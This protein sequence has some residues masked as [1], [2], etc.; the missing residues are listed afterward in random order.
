MRDEF[1]S[2]RSTGIPPL[3]ALAE[4]VA[5]RRSALTSFIKAGKDWPAVI[6]AEALRLDNEVKTLTRAGRAALGVGR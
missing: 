2:L 4:M 3:R 6:F 5:W 1:E